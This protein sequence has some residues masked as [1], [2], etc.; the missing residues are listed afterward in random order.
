MY[1]IHELA[2]AILY[3]NIISTILLHVNTNVLTKMMYYGAKFRVMCTM[4]R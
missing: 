1:F 2:I 4:F 3:E